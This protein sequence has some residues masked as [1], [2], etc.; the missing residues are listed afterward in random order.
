MTGSLFYNTGYYAYVNPY[1]VATPVVVQ[2]PVLNYSM[3][4]Q[5][6]VAPPA[7]NSPAERSAIA[8]SDQARAA[9]YR[10]SYAQALD[11]VDAA[12][13][14]TPS[15]AVLHE[16]RALTLFAMNR[17]Q[18]S[19]AT[20]YA[21][22]SVGPGW[23]WTTMIGLYPSEA[24]YESQL[25]ALE[26]YVRQNPNAP[27]G[28]F[29]LAYQYMTAGHPEA[30]AEQYQQVLQLVP[31]DSVSRQMLSLLTGPDDQQAA[32]AEPPANV[33]PPNASGPPVARA[34]ILGR[35]TASSPAD[36][37]VDF[38]LDNEGRFVWKFSQ[39]NNTQSFAGKFE[40]AGNTLVLEYDNGGTMVA[41]IGPQGP[42]R[43]N[44]Q[45]VGGPSNDPGLAF[46]RTR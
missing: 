17:Y 7:E 38:S 44:F 36:G 2:Y 13:V 1:Y 9:F 40:L 12:L 26:A 4:I 10:G 20:L 22:L 19:A 18:E 43:F 3:P 5:T 16:F 23:D 21:V 8:A 35:W 14:D 31:N 33:P 11:R 46:A 45:M 27:D 34:D 15:D 28:H 39:A 41:K 37:T 29:V 25:H 42:N 6:T 30:A 32:A 24:V